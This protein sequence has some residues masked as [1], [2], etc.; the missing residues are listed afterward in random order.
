MEAARVSTMVDIPNERQARELVPLLD[1][2]DKMAEALTAAQERDAHV[3]AERVRDGRR[4]S[5]PSR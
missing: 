4:R 5:R 3:T 2:P 1:R